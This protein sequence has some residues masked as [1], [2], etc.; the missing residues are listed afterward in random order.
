MCYGVATEA[1]GRISADSTVGSGSVFTIGLPQVNADPEPVSRG[2]DRRVADGSETILLVEDDDSVR[3]LAE[4]VFLEHGYS[5]LSAKDGQEAL[6]VMRRHP[7]E[8]RLVI[9]DIVMPRMGGVELAKRVRVT[10]PEL[11]VLLMSGYVDDERTGGSEILSELPI[12]AKPFSPSALLRLVRDIIDRP[13]PE[14][15]PFWHGARP[16]LRT[17]AR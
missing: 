16:S 10:N 8:I 11:P 15:S 6:R 2:R 17:A 5:V 7:D 9:S 3:K 12:I 4:A 14:R 13:K 1:G